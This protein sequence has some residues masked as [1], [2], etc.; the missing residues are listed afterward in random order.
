VGNVTP[1]LV[2]GVAYNM[3]TNITPTMTA[4]PTATETP[5]FTAMPTVTATPTQPPV[6]V[7]SNADFTGVYP[8]LVEE[9]A[10]E[11]G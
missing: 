4:T 11:E 2:G 3:P 1:Y 10:T 6:P 9:T 8:E 5:T 7:F